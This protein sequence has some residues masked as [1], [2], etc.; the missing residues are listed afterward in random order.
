[1]DTFS[2]YELLGAAA[3]LLMIG[4]Q[5][6]AVLV[7]RKMLVEANPDADRKLAEKPAGKPKLERPL[8]QGQTQP[9]PYLRDVAR[10]AA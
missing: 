2:L 8:G 5:V 10:P 1:M 3:F 4:A 6:L 9:A 7:L